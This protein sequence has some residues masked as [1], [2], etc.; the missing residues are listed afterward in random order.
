M[1]PKITTVAENAFIVHVFVVNATG[2]FKGSYHL[3]LE[4]INQIETELKKK[5]LHTLSSR[6]TQKFCISSLS[7]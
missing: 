3:D 7:H 1:V 2:I 4:N 5:V 6:L